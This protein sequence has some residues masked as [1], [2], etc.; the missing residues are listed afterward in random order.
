MV[1]L[2]LKEVLLGLAVSN[3]MKRAMGNIESREARRPA[4]LKRP[5][6]PENHMM[7][8]CDSTHKCN[9]AS[10]CCSI[11]LHGLAVLSNTGRVDF[12]LQ[13]WIFID[14]HLLF[15]FPI[16]LRIPS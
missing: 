14:F 1:K 4:F 8:S 16:L 15:K 3:P 5:R 7:Y 13:I 11:G 2:C 6:I 9:S 12:A 10:A